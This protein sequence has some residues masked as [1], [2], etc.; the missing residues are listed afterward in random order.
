MDL[1]IVI[2]NYN[3]VSYLRACLHSIFAAHTRH[4]FEVLVVDNASRENLGPVVDEFGSRVRFLFN[5]TNIGF[6]RAVNQAIRASSS[7]FVLVLNPDTELQVDTIERSID[8]AETHPE[9]GALGCRIVNP[10]GTLQLAC[11]RAIPAPR[12]AFFRFV[13][14]SRLFPSSRRLARYNLTYL[15]DQAACEVEAISGSFMLLRRAALD[16][17]G[18]FDES[19]FLF[20]ED[21]DLCLRIRRAGWK[22]FYDP[23]I[24]ILHHKGGSSSTRT[25]R[26]TVDFYHAMW[27]FYRKHHARQNSVVTNALVWSGIWTLG[28][29]RIVAN[30]LTGQRRVGSNG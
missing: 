30:W 11:R 16:Q 18:L 8:S 27:I 20:G 6:G 3:S 25:F 2:V 15:D 1:S 21:L 13:G 7:R 22:V 5:S 19:F 29:A 10:D 26:T 12:D 4:S 17:S 14:L 24:S 9:V 23:S 28:G